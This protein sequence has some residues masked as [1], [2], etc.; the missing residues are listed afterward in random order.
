M[1]KEE[2]HAFLHVE[3]PHQRPRSQFKWSWVLAFALCI[4]VGYHAIRYVVV[5]P[6]VQPKSHFQSGD[7]LRWPGVE[8]GPRR[9]WSSR[10]DVY[11]VASDRG[12]VVQHQTDGD[13]VRFSGNVIIAG[14]TNADN[15]AMT[16]HW[17]A[18]TRT[19]I[20][21][22]DITIEGNHVVI[23]VSSWLSVTADYQTVDASCHPRDCAEFDVRLEVPSSAPFLDLNFLAHSFSIDQSF[24][25]N[26]M[27][28]NISTNVGSIHS[29]TTQ[30]KSDHTV[31]ETSA[32]SIK[33]HYILGKSLELTS[34]V[35]SIN[36]DI[37]VD[38]DTKSPEAHLIT[39][40]TTG[41]VTVNLFAPLK[42][43]NGISARHE[44]VTGSVNVK[45]P[46]EWEG[47]VQASTATGSVTL[48][49]DGLDI[50][51]SRGRWVDRF[52]K[53][54]KGS[55]PDEKSV[56]ECSTSTGSVAFILV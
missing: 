48:K 34:K 24:R 17:R 27:S 20:D 38:T 2:E 56:V 9:E 18:T 12:L 6:L 39:Q 40:S 31:I 22:S 23:H 45:Y 33:G 30:W 3:M 37:E 42:H 43:R 46:E 28:L 4:I 15:V 19:L 51:E 25:S 49:G 11:T 8:C 52:E 26:D 16:V 21:N 50:V 32:G 13:H 35:G 1:D 5:S 47:I 7:R 14:S 29:S 36:V 44:T 41:S 54:I 10:T 53:A 55:D